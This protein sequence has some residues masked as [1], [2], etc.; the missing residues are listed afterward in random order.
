MVV[1]PALALLFNT[2]NYSTVVVP[3]PVFIY[4]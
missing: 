4:S 1:V 3:A 2:N